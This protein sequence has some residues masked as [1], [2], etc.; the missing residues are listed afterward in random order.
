VSVF[1]FAFCTNVALQAEEIEGVNDAPAG[2]DPFA[3]SQPGDEGSMG[4]SGLL[5]SDDGD[6]DDFGGLLGK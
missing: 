2:I 1:V 5:S 4:M 6:E 3:F